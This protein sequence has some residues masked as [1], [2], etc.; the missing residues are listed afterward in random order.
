MINIANLTI[1][2]TTTKN[3]ILNRIKNSDPMSFNCNTII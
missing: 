2:L 1:R 3:T